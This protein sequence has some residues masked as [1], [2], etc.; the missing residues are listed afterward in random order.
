MLKFNEYIKDSCSNTNGMGA[1][2]APQPSSIPVD[3]AVLKNY[4]GCR[5]TYKNNLCRLL[6]VDFG[7]VYCK[8]EFGSRPMFNMNYPYFLELCNKGVI[9]LEE[10]DDYLEE[11]E[12]N[13][14]YLEEYE[15]EEDEIKRVILKKKGDF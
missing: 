7:R 6:N 3:V 15:D 13:D 2:V 10:N 14:D 1:V 8:F 4:I 9:C 12:D 11:Y 5:F